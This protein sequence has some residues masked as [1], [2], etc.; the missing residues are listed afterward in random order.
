LIVLPL[1]M[2]D[3][4]D[5]DIEIKILNNQNVVSNNQNFEPEVLNNKNVELE[6]LAAYDKFSV[7]KVFKNLDQVVNFMKKY[8]IVKGH[9]I[10]I[11]G[12]GRS[13]KAS[14][15]VECQWKVNFWFKNDKNCIEVTTFNDLHVGHKLNPLASQFDPTLCKLPKDIVE[16]IRF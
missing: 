9:E 15:Q 3:L 2:D 10:R 12:G 5:Q 4:T 6:V 8:T 16:E 7:G 11:G 14:C 1:N 13:S